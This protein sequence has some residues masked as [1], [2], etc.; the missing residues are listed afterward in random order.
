MIENHGHHNPFAGAVRCN[1]DLPA[2]E[3][4]LQI[5]HLE[6]NV[7]NSFDNLRIRRIRIESHPLNATR[8][9]FKPCYMDLEPGNVNLIGTR[10]IGRD[11]NVVIT[12]AAAR[13][14][15]RIVAL[16]KALLLGA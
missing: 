11:S 14:S 4:R 12:P 2:F 3:S 15:R 8:A 1:Q 5:I 13:D 6:R 9:G 16:A 10:R 7:G